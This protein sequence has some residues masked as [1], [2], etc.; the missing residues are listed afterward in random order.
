MQ[1]APDVRTGR[2]GAFWS[3]RRRRLGSSAREEHQQVLDTDDV[4]DDVIPVGSLNLD[5]D[6]AQ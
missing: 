6:P 1:S 4:R 2:R 3:T 5:S